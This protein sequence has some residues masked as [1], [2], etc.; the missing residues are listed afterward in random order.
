MATK[1]DIEATKR[2]LE[3][4]AQNKKGFYPEELFHGLHLA[5]SFPYLEV[6]IVRRNSKGKVE[7]LLAYRED[8]DWKGWHIPGGLFRT[9]LNIEEI[10]NQ[11]ALRELNTGVEFLAKGTWEKWMSHHPHGKPFSHIAIFKPTELGVEKTDVRW[12]SK[13]PE[14]LINDGGKHRAFIESILLQVERDKLL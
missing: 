12:F 14:N 7:I 13:P 6:A 2:V 3:E 8:Q 5:V 4:I 9:N 1:A 10:G 11:I